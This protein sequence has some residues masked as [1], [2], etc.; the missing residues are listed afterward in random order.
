[1]TCNGRAFH[2]HAQTVVDQ[3]LR[4]VRGR[5]ATLQ[6]RERT[7]VV[8]VSASVAAALVDD[9]LDRARADPILARALVSIYGPEPAWQPKAVSC[10]RD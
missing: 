9:V 7:A 2:H 6:A 1:M 8:E 10:A 3:E 5:L 4:R